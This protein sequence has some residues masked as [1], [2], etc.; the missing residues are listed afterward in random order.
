MMMRPA[1]F[2]ALGFAAAAGPAAPQAPAVPPS[3]TTY[4]LEQ[5]ARR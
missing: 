3:L 4:V 2:A 5:A 1:L